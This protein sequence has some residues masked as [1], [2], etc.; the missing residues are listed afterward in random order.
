MH[1]AA[2]PVALLY[3]YPG[4]TQPH[5]AC[6]V[7]LFVVS[8]ASHAEQLSA[9][10]APNSRALSAYVS[11][12]HAAAVVPLTKYQPAGTHRHAAWPV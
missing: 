5:A 10:V 2:L 9:P 4:L 7:A 3:S 8:P 6:C 11:A 1:A 12:P